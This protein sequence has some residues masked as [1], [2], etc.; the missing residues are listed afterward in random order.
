MGGLFLRFKPPLGG[1]SVSRFWKEFARVSPRTL[2]ITLA[3]GGIVICGIGRLLA[4]TILKTCFVV[5]VV[6]VLAAARGRNNDA[7]DESAAGGG[8]G[9]KPRPSAPSRRTWRSSTTSRALQPQLS[10][11]YR[12]GIA[13]GCDRGERGRSHLLPGDVRDGG[14][15]TGGGGLRVLLHPPPCFHLNPTRPTPTDSVYFSHPFVSSPPTFFG[16][17]HSFAWG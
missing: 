13:A 4:V 11:K 5:V 7:A 1:N 3:E 9:G 14:I 6:V 8:G 10:G 17:A 2:D 15:G 16:F 12:G